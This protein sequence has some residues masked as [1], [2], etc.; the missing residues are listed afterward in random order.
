MIFAHQP[1]SKYF[2]L[3]RAVNFRHA[4]VYTHNE[5][6]YFREKEKRA[7]STYAFSKIHTISLCVWIRVSKIYTLVSLEL[8]GK[9]NFLA[10]K[11]VLLLDNCADFFSVAVKA[12]LF[13]E[14]L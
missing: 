2:F 4:R 3:Y 13:L 12:L 7:R 14:Q 9:L 1:C 11:A 5:I 8:A 6:V 10:H